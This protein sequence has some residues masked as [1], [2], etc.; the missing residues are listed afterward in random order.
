MKT[1][2]CRYIKVFHR[3]SLQVKYSLLKA[4]VLKRKPS[5]H[6]LTD[7]TS[8]SQPSVFTRRYD[9]DIRRVSLSMLERCHKLFFA[10]WVLFL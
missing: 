3:E 8:N 9:V 6:P 1:A 10:Y 4:Y 5:A 2:M 7:A